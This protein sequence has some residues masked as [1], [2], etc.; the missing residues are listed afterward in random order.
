VICYLAWLKLGQDYPVLA[1][2]LRDITTTRLEDNINHIHSIL[3]QALYEKWLFF[4]PRPKS[5]V[6]SLFPH[7]RII[8]DNHTTQCYHP[9]V[10]FDEVKIY[11]NGKTIFMI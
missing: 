6:N 5:L 8:I 10:S 4:L 7:V 3:F 9:K 2:A 11:Y 1:C